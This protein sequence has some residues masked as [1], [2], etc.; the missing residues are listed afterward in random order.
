MA[1]L[2]DL[3][4][5]KDRLVRTFLV[6]GLFLLSHFFVFILFL[7]FNPLSPSH[8]LALPLSHWTS[9]AGGRAISSTLYTIVGSKMVRF[10]MLKTSALCR[11]TT[12][13]VEALIGHVHWLSLLSLSLLSLAEAEF[14]WFERTPPSVVWCRRPTLKD[15][16]QWS[17]YTDRGREKW[18]ERGELAIKFTSEL[19]ERNH[20]TSH[21]RIFYQ[22]RFIL[23]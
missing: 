10:V 1:F 15:L 9:G 22:G 16:L 18:E 5:E 12:S 23:N 8:S 21:K 7:D 3:G 11:W 2:T 6:C 13:A 20:E 19:V 14:S 17:R 4:R